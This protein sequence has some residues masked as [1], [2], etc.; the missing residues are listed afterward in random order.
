MSKTLKHLHFGNKEIILLGTA[1]I[2]QQSIDDVTSVITE[3]KPD[4]VGI[5]LDQQRLETIKNP[6]AW[7]NIDIIDV[8][9]KGQGFM[10][11][12]NLVL[13]SFQKR[14]G[15]DVGVRPGEEMRVALSTAED[16]GIATVMVDRP[17]QATLRRAWAKNSLW[18][19][20]KLLAALFASAFEQEK[21]SAEEIEKLKN[22]NEMDSMMGE[23]ADYLPTVKTV[24][25]D[26][27]D[28][29][30]A[31]HI[32]KAVSEDLPAQKKDAAVKIVAVLGAGHLAG[33][34]RWLNHLHNNEVSSNTDE[35][36]H[37][38]PA[39]IAGKLLGLALPALII[40]LIV[41]GFFSGGLPTSIDMLKRWL[42]WN[43]SLS[44][45][46]TL[47]AFGHPITVL[48]A[49]IGAPF[50]T[51]SPLLGVGMITGVVQAWVKKPKVEDMEN[52]VDDIS[53]LKGL[54][55]NRIAHVLLILIFSTIGGAIGNFIAVPALFGSIIQ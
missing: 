1:H 2:S 51:L 3:Q 43:C 41:A 12:A 15:S 10:L 32:W 29:Y 36:S 7:R 44:A 5:E 20:A 35:I 24:L 30:L 8:L 34:E 22:S 4:F 47:A 38:P 49:I 54:Y 16:L 25:I 52:L 37:V 50:G 19:K 46:G 26:E 31:C 42:F 39:G 17:I 53:S 9:K 40:G 18:G 27:R 55:R 11:M 45:V 33:V 23:L 48:S 13:S 14:M 21:I 28:Q 6:T